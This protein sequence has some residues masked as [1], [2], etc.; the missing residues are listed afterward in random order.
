MVYH[1]ESFAKDMLLD[2]SFNANALHY[3]IYFTQIKTKVEYCLTRRGAVYI[4]LAMGTL[5]VTWAPIPN[6][7]YLTWGLLL[8]I[9]VTPVQF[10]GGWTFYVG[11]YESIKK[12]TTKMELLIS[13]GTLVAYIFFHGEITKS[14][15]SNMY[16][17]M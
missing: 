5:T 16:R 17:C 10:I 6:M 4:G 12:R 13:I 9:I 2:S 1:L 15:I 8:F 7:P 3:T 11:A 14:K